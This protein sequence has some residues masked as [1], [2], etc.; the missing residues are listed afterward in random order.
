MKCIFR[1]FLLSLFVVSYHTNSSHARNQETLTKVIYINNIIKY[2]S[3][4][5]ISNPTIRKIC[6]VNATT[7]MVD[8]TKQAIAAGPFKDKFVVEVTPVTEKDIT[9]C[10]IVYVS[11]SDIDLA[12]KVFYYVKNKP[13]VT[14]SENEMIEEGAMIS[15][16]YIGDKLRINLD[17]KVM[18]SSGVKIKSRLLEVAHLRNFN[19]KKQGRGY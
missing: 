3:S 13:I 19:N 6:Y 1:I 11:D 9:L 5:S 18:K 15:F 7:E 14:I 17:Y 8:I 2:V 12:K 4:W 16:F 10:S